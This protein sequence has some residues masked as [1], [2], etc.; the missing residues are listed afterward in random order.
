V[1]GRKRRRPQKATVENA[2]RPPERLKTERERIFRAMAIVSCCRYASDSMLVPCEGQP[3]IEGALA[4]AYTLLNT[5]AEELGRM[6]DE[7]GP[8]K[9]KSP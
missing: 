7:S 1:R 3:D 5:S 6:V 8:N 2:P 4:A 9:D